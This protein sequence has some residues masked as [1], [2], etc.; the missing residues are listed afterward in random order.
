MSSIAIW[1]AATF[2]VASQGSN[3]TPV[4]MSYY[5]LIILNTN[6]YAHL[7]LRKERPN[8]ASGS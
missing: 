1:I 6:S 5:L 7:A 8:T 4:A 3:V 2:T